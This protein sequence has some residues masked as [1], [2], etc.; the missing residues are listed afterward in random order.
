MSLPP[1]S[2]DPPD[3]DEF[4]DDDA[5]PY[6]QAVNPADGL[7]TWLALYHF[8]DKRRAVE[9]YELDLYGYADDP[10]DFGLSDDERRDF[11]RNA[12]LRLQHIRFLGDELWRKLADGSLVATGF[13]NQGSLDAGRRPIA[14]ERWQDLELRMKES[15]AS[16]PGVEV[17]QLLIYPADQLRLPEPSSA[18]RHS[19]A[20]LRNWYLERVR[21]M[22]NAAPSREDDHRDANARFGGG[23][24]KR[25]VEALR[26]EL[27]PESWTRK[28]RR[29]R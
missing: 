23:V 29:P 24:P 10:D 14:Q 18:R 28:G 8:I 7:S 20:E 15:S 2:N 27:A 11:A 12:R 21:S 9:L 25:A 6:W 4:F 17:T 19:S 1:E 3:N 13:S 16:G 5:P 26:R 22:G